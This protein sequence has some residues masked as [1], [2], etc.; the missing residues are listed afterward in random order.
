MN[1][2]LK[3]VPR[4]KRLE[5][6]IHFHALEAYIYSIQPRQTILNFDDVCLENRRQVSHGMFN[7]E[8][9]S[10][11]SKAHRIKT[12]LIGC[13][14]ILDNIMRLQHSIPWPRINIFESSLSHFLHTPR[15]IEYT[16]AHESSH[17]Y[18][19]TWA[20]VVSAKFNEPSVPQHPI[21]PLRTQEHRIRNACVPYYLQTCT[22]P[23]NPLDIREWSSVD[24]RRV[25]R[26]SS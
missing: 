26:E 9:V 20:C 11:K 16:H 17:S 5:V 8:N 7:T 19:F 6:Q 12:K 2:C 14:S 22:Q 1:G 25:C 13:I 4:C 24:A 21:T 23:K 18:I 15:P 3:Y 10:V